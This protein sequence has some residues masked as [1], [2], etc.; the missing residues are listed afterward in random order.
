MRAQPS[1]PHGL[2]IEVSEQPPVA[3]LEAG[4]A[5]TALA[6][7]GVS[8]G[9]RLL[10][11]SLPVVHLGTGAEAV[12]PIA[13]HRVHDGALLSQLGVLGAAPRPLAALVTRV[14]MGPH[15]VTVALANRVLVYFGDATR[16]HAKWLSLARVLADASSAGAIYVDVRV[17]ERPAAGFAPGTKPGLGTEGEPSSASDP[18]TAAALAAGLEAAVSGGANPDVSAASTAGS[19]GT[20]GTTGGEASSA[21]GTEASSAGGGEASGAG[22]E[23]SF[24]RQPSSSAAGGAEGASQSGSSGG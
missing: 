22:G 8:L 10:S 23:A 15:G 24:P 4:G 5:R 18:T 20:P 19:P 13:G 2:R 16:P 7:D 1:F 6:A 14:Y 11:G 3:A 9:A 12:L 17:P 21:S